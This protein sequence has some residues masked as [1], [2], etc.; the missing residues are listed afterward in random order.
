[1]KEI[2]AQMERFHPSITKLSSDPHAT[3]QSLSINRLMAFD[4]V[5]ILLTTNCESVIII[6]NSMFLGLLRVSFVIVK[7]ERDL[8]EKSFM[9]LESQQ[10]DFC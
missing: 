2:K 4:H 6:S 5:A 3:F 8:S 1:V 7:F 9:F 10:L